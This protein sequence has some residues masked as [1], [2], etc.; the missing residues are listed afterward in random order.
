MNS[1]NWTLR[2]FML[3]LLF[4][5][6]LPLLLA[7]TINAETTEQPELPWANLFQ[8]ASK[9]PPVNPRKGSGRPTDAVCMVSPDA[10]SETRIVWS[11]RPLFLWQGKVNKIAVRRQGSNTY[12]WSQTVTGTESA[13]YN[14][15][16]LQPGQT[17]DWKVNDNMFVPFRVMQAQPRKQIAEE[18]KALEDQLLS[19]KDHTEEAIALEKVVVGCIARDL[20]CVK[21]LG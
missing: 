5:A 1:C 3:S 7:Q 12:L 8:A 17:Y 15:K 18:L 13:T 10:P 4:I 20:F 21:T 16:P 2:S 19:Q 9:K 11:D 6:G 14:G